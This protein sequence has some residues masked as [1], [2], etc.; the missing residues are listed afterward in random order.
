[1]KPGLI[2]NCPLKFVC[3]K[4]WSDLRAETVDSSRR[5]CT[6]CNKPVYLCRTEEDF[7]KRR[8]AGECVALTQPDQWESQELLGFPEEEDGRSL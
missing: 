7:E 6:D 3:S 2:S 8:R 1:M 5:F 4:R